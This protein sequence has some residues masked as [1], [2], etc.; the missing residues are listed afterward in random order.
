M[1][2]TLTELATRYG[3]L[4]PP[5]GEVVLVIAPATQDA[6]LPAEIDDRLK[7]ALAAGS[8]RDAVSNV[9]AETGAPRRIVYARALN[10]AGAGK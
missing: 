3:A 8:L 7:A 2:G 9:V 6:A 5:K 10:L 1:T 4:P